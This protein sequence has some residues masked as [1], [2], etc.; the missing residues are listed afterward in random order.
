MVPGASGPHNFGRTRSL[1]MQVPNAFKADA[2]LAN[3]QSTVAV[4]A[5]RYWNGL[6]RRIHGRNVLIGVRRWYCNC[7]SALRCSGTG[8]NQPRRE[9]MRPN[10]EGFIC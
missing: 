4:V 3:A 7:A 1:L 6:K 9:L 8:V 10:R 2:R 5:K